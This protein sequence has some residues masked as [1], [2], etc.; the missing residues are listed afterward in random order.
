M[1]APAWF[2]LLCVSVTVLAWVPASLLLGDASA[3]YWYVVAPLSAVASGW[4]FSTRPAQPALRPGLIALVTGV[5][6]LLG[7]VALLSFGSGEWM[8]VAPWLVVGAGLGVFALCWHSLA[9]G[10]VAAV[11]L[12]ASAVVAVVDPGQ[13][14][15]ALA[16]VVGVAAAV[17]TVA[18]LLRTDAVPSAADATS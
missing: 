17:G 14:Q 1:A 3:V 7:V 12:A 10:V 8:D 9:T 6:M 11:T 4:Y 2:P 16:L 13:S 5:A 18:D 15:A